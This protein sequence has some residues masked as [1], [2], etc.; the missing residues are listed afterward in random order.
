MLDM[1]LKMKNISL[2]VFRELLS[3][4]KNKWVAIFVEDYMAVP[5]L[6]PSGRVF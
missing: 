5:C 4:G 6:A 1:I 2:S 3:K